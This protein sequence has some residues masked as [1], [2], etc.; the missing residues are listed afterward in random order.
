MSKRPE[1]QTSRLR[2]ALAM[3]CL[4]ASLAAHAAALE[5]AQ[6]KMQTQDYAA[7]EQLL[8]EVLNSEPDN[9]EARALL[10]RSLLR[11]Q[12]YAEAAE[13]YQW[14]LTRYPQDSDVALGLAQSHLWGG[15]PQ[16]ALDVVTPARE[17]NP[18]YADLW[19][20]NIQALMSLQVPQRDQAL[21]LQTEAAQLFPQASWDLVPPAMP[22]SSEPG[23]VLTNIE[24]TLDPRH[25]QQV[26]LSL[27]QDFLSRG[28]RNWQGV[29]LDLIHRIG[30]RQVVYGALRRSERFDETDHELM[31]GAYLPLNQRLT[32]NVE[33]MYSP[34]HKVVARNSLLASLQYALDDGWV[35]HAGVRHAEYNASSA[36]LLPLG[37]ERYVGNWRFAYSPT[38]IFTEGRTLYNHRIQVSRYYH[39]N[40]FITASYS[41]GE[42]SDQFLSTF[43]ISD[44]YS[45]G[46]NGRHWLNQDWA[47]SWQL[48]QT[49]QGDSYQRNGIGIGLRRAF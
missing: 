7:A 32:L 49:Q 21:S 1:R 15:E 31:A 29:Q 4:L 16:A 17:H 9:V 39:D 35:L 23:I 44:V 43:L 45:F 48:N 20:L 2:D 41:R 38:P 26:E 47:V 6:Q 19:R 5:T 28:N 12:R 24:R 46:L 25:D 33:G 8:R 10:A 3:V 34:A 36:T 30:P 13:A 11:Q 14:L 27:F 18:A 22:A 37:V 40:S 42:E